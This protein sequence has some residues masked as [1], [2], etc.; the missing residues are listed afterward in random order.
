MFTTAETKGIVEFAVKLS[1][2]EKFT[3]SIE[4]LQILLAGKTGDPGFALDINSYVMSSEQSMLNDE[5]WLDATMNGYW[6]KHSLRLK[7]LHSENL[8]RDYLQPNSQYK[9]CQ[10]TKETSECT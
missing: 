2:L 8:H 10:F 1:I 3:C 4:V 5:Q 9:R 7:L 6:Q